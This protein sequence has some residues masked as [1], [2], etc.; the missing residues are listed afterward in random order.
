MEFMSADIACLG[1]NYMFREMAKDLIAFP[2][3]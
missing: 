1:G 2:C 3:A